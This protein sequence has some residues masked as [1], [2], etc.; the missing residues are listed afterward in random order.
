M[1]LRFE[2]IDFDTNKIT[3]EDVERLR[4]LLPKDMQ[5]PGK[6]SQL[7]IIMEAIHYIKMLQ[8]RLGTKPEY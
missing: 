3:S 1:V 2:E 7:E 4:L 6:L 8:F 5:E